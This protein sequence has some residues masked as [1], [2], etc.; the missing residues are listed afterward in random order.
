MSE[1]NRNPEQFDTEPDISNDPDYLAF[2][3]RTNPLYD[4]QSASELEAAL[5]S[6]NAAMLKLEAALAFGREDT[7][8]SDEIFGCAR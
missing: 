6:M 2:C 8:A 5:E 3:D 7:T 4:G 1:A